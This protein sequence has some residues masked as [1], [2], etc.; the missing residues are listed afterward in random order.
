MQF[1]IDVILPL[2]LEKLFT[3]SINEEEAKFLKPGMRVAVPFGKSKVYTAIVFQVHQAAPQIY[4]AKEIHQ[5]LDEHAVVHPKQLTFWEWIASYYMCSM[6]DVMRAALPK[7]FLLESE[8]IVTKA[9]SKI[10]DES[11]LTDD[12]FVIMEA[13]SYQ[14]A[15]SIGD[16]AK[17]LDKKQVLKPIKKLIGLGLIHLHE[18]VVEQYVPKLVKYVRLHARVDE[19]TDLP[20]LLEQLSRAKK[21]R[22]AILGFY[23]LQAA[24]KDKPIKAKHLEERAQVSSAVLKA[25]VDKEI[26]EY[27]YIQTDRNQFNNEVQASKELNAHQQ[28]AFQEIQEGFIENDVVLL[29]GV[30]ASGKTELYVKFIEAVFKQEKQVLFLLPEIAL[31]TQLIARLKM[32]FGD[33]IVVFHSRY[34][35]NERVESWNKVL[36]YKDG[37]QLVIGARSSIFMPFKDLGLIVVDEEHEQSYKQFDPA[38]RYHARDAA[39]VLAKLYE[40]KVILGSATPSIESYYNAKKGKYGLV[41]LMVRHNNMLM[42]DIELVDL[43]DQYKRKRMKGHFS[44]RLL[45]GITEALD[46]EEQV[47]L[48][49][50]RRGYSP[51]VECKS[52]GHVPQCT[53]C[54]VSLTYHH[55][56]NQLR[57]HYCGYTI[58]M[59]LSC[60]ACGSHELDTKGLGTEQI[61]KELQELFPEAKVMRMDLDTTRG[62]YGHQKIIAAFEQQE[63]DIL[64][65]TQMLTKGLDF[66]KVSL[67]GIL[68]ADSMLNF[69]DFRAHERSY[70]LMSQVAGR[71]GR[72]E[73]KGKVL[74]QTYNPDHNIL[75][76]VSMHRYV[77]MYAEQLDQRHIYSYP[78]TNRLIKMTFRHRDYQKVNDGADWFA[79]SLR[80]TFGKHVLGPEFPPVARVRNEYIKNVLLKIPMNQSVG[81]TKKAILKI[82]NS[83]MSIKD[84]RPIK[85]ILNVDNY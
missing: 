61:E 11:Q 28:K 85:V 50:N 82:K 16:I 40:A 76:Q 64:V 44:E 66:K 27:Y 4:E 84:F 62:K 22:E 71:A 39:V 26:L 8:T 63:V 53:N 57:C 1:F 10:E 33:K 48:F 83:F 74:I 38:P 31:T 25:L 70:Q 9:D 46:K 32:Y 56:R 23:S 24:Y 68:N 72:S 7:A 20:L 41:N 60:Q 5:I 80:A 36:N 75:Q 51:V 77:E 47:I 45:L 18:E 73:N 67:V 34:S 49:Q 42:P 79:K 6:G 30:T 52:C 35:H 3:Y 29:Y 17:I 21:Q 69:P 58:A 43:K 65:G 12:E 37:G 2:P 81:K 59:Q 78:P 14:S 19:K 55:Y 13:L 15:I 54:D